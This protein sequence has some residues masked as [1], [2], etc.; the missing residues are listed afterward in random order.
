MDH[1]QTS[2]PIILGLFDLV[3]AIVA[4]RYVR[5]LSPGMIVTL[6]SIAVLVNLSG[7]FCAPN[8]VE[9]VAIL[10]APCIILAAQAKRA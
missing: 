9:V 1:A 4:F 8:I 10:G 3:I 7:L 5:R 2:V 6:S